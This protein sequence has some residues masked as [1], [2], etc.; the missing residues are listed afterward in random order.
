MD[1]SIGAALIG[2][3][4]SSAGQAYANYQQTKLQ[5]DANDTQIKLANTAHQR[6][7]QDLIA[8]GINPVL[9]AG[10]SG[11]ST[12]TLGV[13]SVGNVGDGIGKGISDAKDY[14]SDQYRAQIANTEA[15]TDN[16]KVQNDNLRADSVLKKA[17]A[18]AIQNGMDTIHSARDTMESLGEKVG[19][20]I[21]ESSVKSHRP[22]LISN[23][24]IFDRKIGRYRPIAPQQSSAQKI[25][26]MPNMGSRLR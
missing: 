26:D 8:A 2:G 15:Q 17:Q 20:K 11:S 10:G 23:G 1:A 9:T 6:E 19:D 5:R 16:L 24:L 22:S 14:L 7:V 21:G 25:M 12:P 13:P 18:E 3:A 4:L